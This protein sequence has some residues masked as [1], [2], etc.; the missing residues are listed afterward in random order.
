MHNSYKL[1]KEAIN[2]FYFMIGIL[3]CNV[4]VVCLYTAGGF[5]ITNNQDMHC[6][7]NRKNNVIFI[8]F[9]PT[10]IALYKLDMN[11][12]A[13]PSEEGNVFLFPWDVPGFFVSGY[14]THINTVIHILVQTPLPLI[15]YAY[16]LS[17]CNSAYLFL[18]VFWKYICFHN[19][20]TNVQP[21]SFDFRSCNQIRAFC[22]REHIWHYKIQFHL[23]D[24][25]FFH[26]HAVW[27]LPADS[28]SSPFPDICIETLSA[29]ETKH[30]LCQYI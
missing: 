14:S 3:F 8:F 10:R 2:A 20:P 30:S 21:H 16:R 26:F 4:T 23:M 15:L 1:H 29:M 9:N 5:L 18:K 17:I 22:I 13:V 11:N 24:H 12:F 19:S 6:I 25:I 27:L 7:T 28:A